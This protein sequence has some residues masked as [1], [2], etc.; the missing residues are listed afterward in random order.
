MTPN[1]IPHLTQFLGQASSQD[2][3]LELGF[4]HGAKGVLDS[5]ASWPRYVSVS[6][7]FP[8]ILL[9][10]LF[11]S[12]PLF[13]LPSLPPSL[14]S[15]FPSLDSSLC[16]SLP[17]FRDLGLE[18]PQPSPCMEIPAVFFIQHS[19]KCVHL[20]TKSASNSVILAMR[21]L[22]SESLSDSPKVIA[23]GGTG[24]KPRSFEAHLWALNHIGLHAPLSQ[25]FLPPLL[26]GNSY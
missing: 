20:L 13:L 5:P 6:L 23:N 7:S 10:S 12:L 22:S 19:A 14:F 15:S 8:P 16:P 26:L 18:T 9:P 1:P 25:F 3:S 21:K 17:P 2:F 24:F 11:S 4:L